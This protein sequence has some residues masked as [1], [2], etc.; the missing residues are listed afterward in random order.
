MQIGDE[1]FTAIDPARHLDD[2][3]AARH[4]RATWVRASSSTSS[5]ASHRRWR[6]LL[7]VGLAAVAVT[8]GAAIVVPIW[9]SVD[10]DTRVDPDAVIPISY[11]TLSGA[12]VHCTWA[13]YVGEGDRTTDEIRVAVALDA[14]NW[15]GVGQ[16]IYEQA[17]SNPRVPQPDE[18]WTNDR[19]ETR[20]MISFKLAV[21]PVVERRLPAELIALVHWDGFALVDAAALLRINPSTVR[22]RYARAKDRLATRLARHD[23]EL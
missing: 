3:S 21:L 6:V 19:A 12:Q 4:V 20:D 23:R 5:H 17:L 15:D 16:D 13:V 18:T 7:P 22:T 11:T 1:E 10:G 14:T 9:M 8:T 2:E